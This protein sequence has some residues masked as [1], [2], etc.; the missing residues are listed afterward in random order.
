MLRL[1]LAAALLVAGCNRPADDPTPP[2]TTPDD[3]PALVG[4]HDGAYVVAFHRAGSHFALGTFTITT[5]QLAGELRNDAGLTVSVTGRVKRDGQM[6][7]SGLNAQPPTDL[8]MIEGHVGSG[9]LEGRY[10]LD[11]QEGRFSGTLGGRLANQD[12]SPVFDGTYAIELTAGDEELAAT[13]LE[14]QNGRLRAHLTAA[15]GFTTQIEGVVTD[16]GT[17]VVTGAVSSNGADVLAEANIDHESKAIEGIFR[18]RDT[19]GRVT[20]QRSD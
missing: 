15:D 8:A 6:E 3:E 12:P 10:T 19:V 4:P 11:G 5:N 16:D 7:L 9:V 1:L 2:D 14:V 13:V 20:G 18:V 17:I